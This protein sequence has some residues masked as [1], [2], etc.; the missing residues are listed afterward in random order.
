MPSD[1]FDGIHGIHYPKNVCSNKI[2]NSNHNALENNSSIA[3]ESHNS[4]A[5]ATA[6]EVDDDSVVFLQE[7][8]VDGKEKLTRQE[9]IKK[10]AMYN[11]QKYFFFPKK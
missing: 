11:V 1:S 6:E 4:S 3:T 5:V 9:N 7:L 10:K 2:F 8:S